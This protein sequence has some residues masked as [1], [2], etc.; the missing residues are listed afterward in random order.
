[1]SYGSIDWKLIFK[2]FL[3]FIVAPWT[4]VYL[5]LLA[6]V[7]KQGAQFWQVTAGALLVGAAYLLT[8]AAVAYFAARGA[9]QRPIVHALLA[10]ALGLAAY[11]AFFDESP[12]AIV[13]WPAMGALG[14]LPSVRKMRNGA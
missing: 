6:I 7:P 11:L 3:A 9:R 10:V 13:V 4:C 2:T 5:L 8:P 1:M 12:F 14:V